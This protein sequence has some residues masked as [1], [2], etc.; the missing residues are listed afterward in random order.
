MPCVFTIIQHEPDFFPIWH[1]YYSRHFSQDE[2][3]VLHHHLPKP[4]SE[5]QAIR[6]DAWDSFFSNHHK[7]Y[8][9]KV[10]DIYN[11]L[12]FN[13]EWL[14]ETVQE[15][16]RKLLET[17][18]WVLFT[19][20]D[21]IVATHPRI[22]IDIKNYAELKFKNRN[23]C[24]TDGYEVVQNLQFEP[25]IDLNKP[26]LVQRKEWYWS[27][28][29][30]KPLLTMIPLNYCWGFH[31][32]S[33]QVTSYHHRDRDLLLIHL[34]KLDWDLCLRRNLAN[35][36]RDWCDG[37]FGFQN[38]LVAETR[39]RDWWKLNIDQRTSVATMTPIPED[40]KSII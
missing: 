30:S 9:Y 23:I 14:K 40:V 35:S 27:K 16:Q 33:Q 32:C 1:R 5:S 21:E 12:S 39:L 4:K 34:H 38:R 7:Q 24:V 6:K 13:H 3:V 25:V 22:G 17:S 11:D 20:V 8:G 29:Y 19:E 15:H 36:D 10:V 26:L 18:R 37:T 28:Q 31:T 2:I